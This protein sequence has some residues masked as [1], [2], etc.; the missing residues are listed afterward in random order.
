MND[1]STHAD[2]ELRREWAA[3]NTADAAADARDTHPLGPADRDENAWG[4]PGWATGLA[5]MI[6][7]VA[8]LFGGLA[9]MATDSCGPDNCSSALNRALAGVLGGLFATVIGTPAMLLAGWVLPRRMRFAKAR[10]IIA[11]CALLPPLI[12]ILMVLGLPE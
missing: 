9:P 2:A 12:V 3:A 7:P 6:V 11:W 5:L 4:A 10:R 1:R 8:L